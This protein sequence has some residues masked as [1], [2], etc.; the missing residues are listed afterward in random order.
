MRRTTT[1][2]DT[3]EID[4]V[5]ETLIEITTGAHAPVT[6]CSSSA[7]TMPLQLARSLLAGA[8]V[9]SQAIGRTTTGLLGRMAGLLS[10]LLG[11]ASATETHAYP[12]KAHSLKSQP[13]RT[14]GDVGP[15]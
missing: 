10:P 8:C 4:Q 13:E 15:K 5:T 3:P 14:N 12:S 7:L 9:L 2:S 11:V 1:V 6:A